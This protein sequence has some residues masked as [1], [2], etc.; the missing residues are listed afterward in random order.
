MIP[1]KWFPIA[2]TSIVRLSMMVVEVSPSASE[3]YPRVCLPYDSFSSVGRA[4]Y[5]TS[6]EEK[7]M[8]MQKTGGRGGE[9]GPEFQRWS[10]AEHSRAEGGIRL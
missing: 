9:E 1:K 2:P 8:E 3:R 4:S 7:K 6:R 5:L 10:R